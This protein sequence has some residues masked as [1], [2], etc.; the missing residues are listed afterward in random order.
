MLDTSDF[1]TFIEQVK[2]ILA[3]GTV[4]SMCLSDILLDYFDENPRVEVMQQEGGGEGGAEN[5]FTVLR[6]DDN[7]YKVFYNYYSHEG[8][9]YDYAEVRLVSPK[10]KTITVYE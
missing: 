5:C 8:F 9:C 6:V 7:Y 3:E 2:E 1:D 4:F 10:E